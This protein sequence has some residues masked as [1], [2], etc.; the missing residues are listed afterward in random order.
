[1]LSFVKEAMGLG[2][3]GLEARV[4]RICEAGK[5][6]ELRGLL[7]WRTDINVNAPIYVCVRGRA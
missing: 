3:K 6:Q 4:V 2:A 5:A 1:M 7:S